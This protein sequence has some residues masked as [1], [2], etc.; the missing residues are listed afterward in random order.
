MPAEMIEA[1]RAL[2]RRGWADVNLVVSHARRRAVIRE[3]MAE[4]LAAESPAETLT[5]PKGS[6]ANSQ[7]RTVWKG[8]VLTAVLDSVSRYEIY[9]AQLLVL[10]GWSAD[11]LRLRCQE[12]GQEYEVPISWASENLRHGCSLCYA[13]IQSRTCRGTV[14][15]L[16][17][18]SP[19]FTRRHLIMGLSRATAIEK[20][21]LGT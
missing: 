1:A 11:Q 9:N 12:G 21:W 20:V 2:P 13:A 19:R 3:V 16:D 8:T 7:P 6:D 14:Q 17:W 15:L 18:Q 4:R 10:E 5:I